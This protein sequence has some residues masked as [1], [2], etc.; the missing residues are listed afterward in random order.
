MSNNFFKDSQLL[1]ICTKLSRILGLV[2]D[3]IC[4][5]MFGTSLLFGAFTMAFRLPNL[6]R[7][8]FG[9]GA[10]TAAF[11]PQFVDS[12]EK[13]DKAESLKFASSILT[14]MLLLLTLLT[15][16]GMLICHYAIFYMNL[17]EKLYYVFTFSYIMLPYL[18][19]IC[20]TAL[21]GSMLNSVKHFLMPALAPI[22]SNALWIL[23]L[24][25]VH[26]QVQT[27][28]EQLIGLCVAISISGV[29]QVVLLLVSLKKLGWQ[30]SLQFDFYS[31]RFKNVF[32]NFLPVT[33]SM[34]IF[35]INVFLDSL[36]ALTMVESE[37]AVAALYYSDRIQQLPLGV[38][39][40]SIATA[41]YPVLSR[42]QSQNNDLEFKITT[43]KALRGLW[44][45][46]IP[47]TIGIIALKSSLVKMFFAFKDDISTI[48]TSNA[49][50][51]YSFGL[52]FTCTL[53]ILTRCFYA[54]GDMKTPVKVGIYMVIL[55]LV[56]NVILIKT[57]NLNGAAIAL[58][59][60]ITT[61]LNTLLLFTIA[62]KKY[63]MIDLA[64]LK[65]SSLKILI[66]NIILGVYLLIIVFFIFRNQE[67]TAYVQG[68]GLSFDL[69][70][71]LFA[72]PT[73]ILLYFLTAKIIRK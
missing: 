40:I 24:F 42:L 54:K 25:L 41:I 58:A 59:T 13:E 12:L 18:I 7:R 36:F 9:E 26:W 69:I 39:S 33:F 44:F 52:V 53:P 4:G 60:S 21:L 71:I 55:N 5:R 64:D 6:F 51:C 8:L 1:G 49:L 3:N 34:A 48:E 73:A 61:T 65:K 17:D 2:R 50:L 16:I 30:L 14:A 23:A 19:F 37:H 35:Q 70:K 22:L 15:L 28:F 47:A 11:I 45:L 20:L 67:V 63:K 68:L 56:L 27:Q 38:V 46:V 62:C 29:L 57:T 66:P 31:K 72:T 10:L 32:F 43:T